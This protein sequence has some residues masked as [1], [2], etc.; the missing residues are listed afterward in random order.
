MTTNTTT[1]NNFKKGNNSTTI[2]NKSEIKS[3]PI[4]KHKN[5]NIH[6]L[7]KIIS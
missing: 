1:N 4:K 6:C 5:K 2:V 3:K 7:L